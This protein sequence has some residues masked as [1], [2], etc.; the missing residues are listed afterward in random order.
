LRRVKILGDLSDE[1]LAR[2]VN[3]MEL[4]TVRQWSQ[5]VK[6]G[7]HGDAMFL[8]LDGEVRVR[9]LIEGKETTLVTLGPGDFFGEVS[10]FDQGP[11]SADVVANSDVLLLKISH[12]AFENLCGA[13]PEVAA[14]ILVGIGKTLTARI[15]ADNKRYRD[16]V[17]LA[18]AVQ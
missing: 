6:Q 12:A 2:F 8:V 15:R 16:S 1:D 11:R 18:R 17:V 14:P 3:F 9:L 10:L 5:I 7:D 4:Q 13:A